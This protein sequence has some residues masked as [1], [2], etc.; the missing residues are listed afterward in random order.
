MENLWI[1][2]LILVAGFIDAIAGGGG[3][4][5]LPSVALLVGEGVAAIATNKILAVAASFTALAVYWFHGHVRLRKSVIFVLSTGAGSIV[6]ARIGS[7]VTAEIFKGLIL[8]IVPVM[9]VLILKRN[10]LIAVS[11][12]GVQ[13]D[14]ASAPLLIAIGLFC[15]VYD[16]AFGP[17]GGTLMFL[18]LATI[19]RL[20]LL[21][22]LASSKMANALSA[23]GS[24]ISYSLSGHVQWDKGLPLAAFI[25]A[26]ALIG[27]RV[28]SKSIQKVIKPVLVFVVLM[29]IVKV[30][31]F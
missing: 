12:S 13:S 1:G 22:A 9:L 6:G 24:L 28:A 7:F 29:L 8:A 5:S 10:K 14:N 18:S 31:F 26:G 3:L 11:C 20:P 19:A 15:G 17:G 21:E 16:G 30:V 2:L 23:T 27:S 25:V 4:I